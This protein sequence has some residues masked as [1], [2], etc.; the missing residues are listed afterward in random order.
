MPPA[1]P[2]PDPFDSNPILEHRTTLF[3]D[4]ARPTLFERKVDGP[5]EYFLLATSNMDFTK[6]TLDLV[7]DLGGGRPLYP[8]IAP[9]Y[10]PK[11]EGDSQ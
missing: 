4:H 11:K 10:P 3:I 6:A 8:N 9:D 5:R 1:V 7:I 2:E